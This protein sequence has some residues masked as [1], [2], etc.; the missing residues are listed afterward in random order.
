MVRSRTDVKVPS[1]LY[2]E[3]KTISYFCRNKLRPGTTGIKRTR[4]TKGWPLTSLV[5]APMPG[6]LLLL[7]ELVL[8]ANASGPRDDV[9]YEYWADQSLTS[10]LELLEREL[11]LG[12]EL[13]MERLL[14]LIERLEPLLMEFQAWSKL[15]KGVPRELCINTLR[16]CAGHLSVIASAR[17]SMSSSGTPIA[18][19]I[20][21]SI[22]IS[23]VILIIIVTV[24]LAPS[25]IVPRSVSASSSPRWRLSPV[26]KTLF[27][28]PGR[29]SAY[30]NH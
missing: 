1:R 24:P 15:T 13:I 29:V 25:A 3:S 22:A 12:L 20:A 27:N 6:C 8:I 23:I 2:I 30:V 18:M 26:V 16:L 4:I 7:L 14:E 10:T 9:L 11:R 19:P 28:S 21:V 5:R 17:L